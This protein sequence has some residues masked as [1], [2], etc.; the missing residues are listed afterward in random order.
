M[1]KVS[2]LLVTAF[3]LLSFLGLFACTPQANESKYRI[4]LTIAPTQTLVEG[5]LDSLTQTQIE[6][7]VLLPEGAIPES[8]E[9][10]VDVISFLERCDV[11]YYVGDLG[12]ETKWIETVKQLNPS[13]KLVRLDEG[14]QHIQVEHK[15]GD[16]IHRIADPHYWVSVQGLRVMSRNIA[17]D[18]QQRF[19]RQVD[20]SQWD[21]LCESLEEQRVRI[22][23]SNVRR[24][25]QGKTAAF[26]V[27][28]PALT[29]YATECQFEQWVIEHEGKEPTAQHILNLMRLW[30][31]YPLHT[32]NI[33][34]QS[35]YEL[36][37]LE[38]N[39][40]VIVL[41]EYRDVTRNIVETYDLDY[42]STSQGIFEL[43]VFAPNIWD[44]MYHSLY[45]LA[46][47]E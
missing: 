38:G 37:L 26:I 5:M 30:K 16:D 27:Y 22:A 31:P 25:E 12:F 19:P 17:K 36:N 35:E 43:N 11:W 2:H 4:A 9:P 42:A 28:H 41:R 7:R 21:S 32:A 24:R 13:I 40:K 6:F 8:Y 44:I 20:T 33:K 10:T 15:H 29:Y 34:C 18:L 45:T 3:A 47:S 1:I 39:P 23:E 14:L 46:K